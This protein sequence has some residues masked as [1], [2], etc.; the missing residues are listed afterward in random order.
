MPR[1]NSRPSASNPATRPRPA[2][3]AALPPELR[4][5]RCLSFDLHGTLI[6]S[7]RGLSEGL[8]AVLKRRGALL[9]SG[10]IDEIHAA[11]F[12]LLTALE[13]Y[14]GY[15]EL[16]AEAIVLG[17]QRRGLALTPQE[18]CEVTAALDQWPAFEDAI[19]AL[20]RLTA[21]YPIALVA[22]LSA[23]ALQSAAARLE[24]PRAHLIDADKVLC[25][26]PE[27]DHLLAL[28]HERELEPEE[29]LHVSAAPDRDL[30]AAE[31]LGIPTVHLARHR[32]PLPEEITATWT[33]LGLQQLADGLLGDS[34]GH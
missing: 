5:V 22:N 30:A 34:A 23:G 14:R 19:P 1:P 20:R 17:A 18:A 9:P 4:G 29:L 12:E 6:D 13:E 8:F 27:P 10:L 21:R 28:L 11:E 26:K 3:A 2:R 32:E 31:D 16:L 33:V 15:E 7:S 24:V 25:F